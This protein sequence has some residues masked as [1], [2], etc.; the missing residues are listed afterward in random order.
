M[1][2]PFQPAELYY[3]V[4][5]DVLHAI[6]PF[7]CPIVIST[8]GS[9]VAREPYISALRSHPKL[10]VQFSFSTTED[11]RANAVEPWSTKPSKLLRVMETL[12]SKGITTTVRWQPYIRGVSENPEVF[13]T[14]VARAG[15]RHLAIEHLKIPVEQNRPLWLLMAQRTG[16]DFRNEL[17][18][19]GARRNGREFVLPPEETVDTILSVRAAAHSTGLT[20]GAADNEFQYLSDTRCCC[21][22]VDQFPGFES[23][24]KHQIGYA[25][26]QSIGRDISYSR[27]AK[28]WSPP[29]YLDRH[30]NSHCRSKGGLTMAAHVENHWNEA[31]RTGAPSS[32]YGVRPSGRLEGRSLVYEWNIEDARVA[33]ILAGR[34]PQS[35][36]IQS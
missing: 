12:A 11:G 7:A 5:R 33:A 21:S 35:E 30:L 15:A 29:G 28:E 20:F 3:R 6:E 13:A 31:G 8:R 23:F 34:T 18:Q 36:A 17:V 19:S 26:R 4:T 16:R 27:I 22:G 14:R 25:V 24:Y 32:F 10:V 9:L 1:S 2:D